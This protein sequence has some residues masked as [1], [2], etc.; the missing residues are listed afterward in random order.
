MITVAVL[1]E[2]DALVAVDKPCDVLSVPG[3]QPG[4]PAPTHKRKR[5]AEYWTDALDARRQRRL[6]AIGNITP[7]G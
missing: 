1:Y 3:R 7:G 6:L 2:D 5:R 4:M